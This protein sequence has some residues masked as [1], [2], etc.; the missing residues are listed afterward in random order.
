MEGTYSWPGTLSTGGT[1][2]GAGRLT[3]SSS[4]SSRQG[5]MSTIEWVRAGDGSYLDFLDGRHCVSVKNSSGGRLSGAGGVKKEA[6]RGRRRLLSSLRLANAVLSL[7]L[8][9][10]LRLHTARP[11]PRSPRCPD[12]APARCFLEP[13][14]PSA[15]CP[16]SPLCRFRTA[17]PSPRLGWYGRCFSHRDRPH[18]AQHSFD[19]R[20]SLR[21]SL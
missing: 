15:A 19:P 10:R 8:P 7:G 14:S 3:I 1:E 11:P 12:P 9:P 18:V 20:P 5:W 4:I 2:G 16:G 6:R 13:A 17:A 21:A